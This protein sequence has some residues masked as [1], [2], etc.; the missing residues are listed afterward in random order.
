MSST[1]IV[2]SAIHRTGRGRYNGGTEQGNRKTLY[3]TKCGRNNHTADRC[4][5]KQ[6][7]NKQSSSNCQG[8]FSGFALTA[9]SNGSMD[10]VID[11]GCTKLIP[12]T[13]QCSRRFLCWKGAE[14]RCLLHGITWDLY[15]LLYGTQRRAH[16]VREVCFPFYDCNKA[17]NTFNLK[18]ALYVSSF[19]LYLTSVFLLV[20]KETQ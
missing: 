17:R 9:T 8:G 16:G 14:V 15:N 20:Y 5:A 6:H 19:K 12:Q 18:R 7:I 13:N 11:C 1:F 3:S 4:Y 10:I 2:A